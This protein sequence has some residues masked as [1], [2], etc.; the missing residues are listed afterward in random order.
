[1][2][3]LGSYSVAVTAGATVTEPGAFFSMG[4]PVSW[5]DMT[6]SSTVALN[7]S[8]VAAVSDRMDAGIM[9]TNASAASQP[10]FQQSALQG[11]DT[12]NFN[13]QTNLENSTVP[14]LVAGNGARV[15]ALVGRFT[16]GNTNGWI[17]GYGG[18]GGANPF[19]IEQANGTTIRVNNVSG[20]LT[21]PPMFTANTP[22]YFIVHCPGGTMPLTSCVLRTNGTMVG[23]TP[24]GSAATNGL[25]TSGNGLFLGR[26]PGGSFTGDLSEVVVYGSLT[27]TEVDALEQ[28]LRDKY[29]L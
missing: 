20:T 5:F 4:Q 10:M 19:S 18:F 21:T 7:N 22:F 28:H 15:V 11:L 17:F 29:A 3:P 6:N 25:I 24:M 23:P 14:P 26:G 9:V 8:T 16:S 27:S 12:L 1:L 2:L 13:V